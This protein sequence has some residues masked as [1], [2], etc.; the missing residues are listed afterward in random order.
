M[1][2]R[3]QLAWDNLIAAFEVEFH[4]LLDVATMAAKGGNGAPMTALLQ[5]IEALVEFY[6]ECTAPRVALPAVLH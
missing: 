4:M 3:E 2:G 1:N 6:N 5:R